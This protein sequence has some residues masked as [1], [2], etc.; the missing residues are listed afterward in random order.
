M[1]PA[2]VFLV[3][4]TVSVY[5]KIGFTTKF[6]VIVRLI[7]TLRHFNPHIGIQARP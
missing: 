2:I 4:Y 5:F 1:C 7:V 3:N 6:V